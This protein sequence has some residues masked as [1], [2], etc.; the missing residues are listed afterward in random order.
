VSTCLSAGELSSEI[1]LLW[2]AE[3][4]PLRV[5]KSALLRIISILG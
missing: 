1:T 3:E 5:L 4:Q 2:F